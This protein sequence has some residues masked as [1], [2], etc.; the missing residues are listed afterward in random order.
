MARCPK[1]S[2]KILASHVCA[3]LESHCD[4]PKIPSEPAIQARQTVCEE[5]QHPSITCSDVTKLSRRMP[6][7]DSMD[8][9]SIQAQLKEISHAF[10]IVVADTLS[11]H[12]PEDERHSRRSLLQDTVSR[13]QNQRAEKTGQSEDFGPKGNVNQQ[14]VNQSFL[15]KN[16]A[17][18]QTVKQVMQKRIDQD[19]LAV[20]FS[21]IREMIGDGQRDMKAELEGISMAIGSKCDRMTDLFRNTFASLLSCMP[22]ATTYTWTF[23]GYLSLLRKLQ[24]EES[25]VTQMLEPVYLRGYCVSTG[26]SIYKLKG[27]T[28]FLFKL[29]KGKLDEF[30]QWPFNLR[31]RFRILHPETPEKLEHCTRPPSNYLERFLRPQNVA[32]DHVLILDKYFTAAELV[33]QGFVKDGRILFR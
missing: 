22:V 5:Q 8:T 30:L 18:E 2:E 26:I 29:H 12:A 17:L 19:E 24:K 7:P 27:D 15:E 14:A 23:K 4:S 1:C 25:I 3:H 16:E 11:D 13:I 31:M 21:E 6:D 32:N 9:S 10:K 33:N 28:H 20:Q